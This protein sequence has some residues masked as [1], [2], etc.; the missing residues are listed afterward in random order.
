MGFPGGS[1]KNLPV[2]QM[3]SILGL[4][5]SPRGGNGNPLQYSCWEI[6]WAEG[7]SSW[8]CKEM[9]RAEETEH[10]C[11]PRHIGPQFFNQGLN[12]CLLHCKAES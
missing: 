10:S 6:P 8:D 4:G 7:Y 11:W 12:P 3:G 5:R 1:I 2:M 9:D